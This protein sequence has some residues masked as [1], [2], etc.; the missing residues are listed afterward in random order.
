M[1]LS[2]LWKSHL[3]LGGKKNVLGEDAASGHNHSAQEEIA[4]S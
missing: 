3:P 4:L 1:K 2:I